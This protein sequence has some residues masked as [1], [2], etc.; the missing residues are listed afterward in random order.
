MIKQAVATHLQQLKD[1]LVQLSPAQFVEKLPVLS[2]STIGMHVRHVVEFYECLLESETTQ[3]VDY[4]AR[5]RNATLENDPQTCIGAIEVIVDRVFRH[6]E[7]FPIQLCANYSLS[8]GESTSVPTTFLRE[9]LYNI[10]HTVHH[11]AIIKIGVKHLD[12]DTVLIDEQFGV[13]IS[14]LRNRKV[15]AP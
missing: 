1:L 5:K 11:L 13:A 10:E 4:D 7:D 2:Y 9:L 12:T 8:E 14:T 3:Q 15:C 6:E